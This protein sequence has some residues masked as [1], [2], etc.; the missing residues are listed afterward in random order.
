MYVIID[1]RG[2]GTFLKDFV[3]YALKVG[4]SEKSKHYFLT[5]EAMHKGTYF[6]ALSLKIYL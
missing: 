6:L 2:S 1:W 3:F 5:K 4:R